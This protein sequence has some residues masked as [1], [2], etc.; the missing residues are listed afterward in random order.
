[1]PT[2]WVQLYKGNDWGYVYL[3]RKAKSMGDRRKE[4]AFPPGAR[5]RVKWPNGQEMDDVVV[6]QRSWQQVS[7]MGRNSTVTSDVAGLEVLVR[8]VTVWVCLDQV[9]VTEASIQAAKAALDVLHTNEAVES[10]EDERPWD[11]R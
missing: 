11:D 7:D 4:I 10:L 5:V 9:Q 1:M 2:K 3:G 8:G 6:H